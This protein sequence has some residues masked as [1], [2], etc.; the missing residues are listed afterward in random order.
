MKDKVHILAIES[1][2]D[3]TSAAVLEN[4]KVKSNII[5]S[6]NVHQKYGGVVPELASRDHEKNIGWLVDLSLKEAGIDL[7]EIDAIAVTQGPGLLGSLIVGVNFAKSLAM[8][9]E[10]PIIAVNHMEAH[11]LA[12]F[13][14]DPRIHQGLRFPFLAL[15]VSGGHTQLYLW[16]SDV[17]YTIL[18][19]TLDDAAGEAFDKIAKLLGL[20][21]PGGPMIDRLSQKGNAGKFSFP[22][23]KVEDF[24]FSFSGLKTAVLYFLQ[25]KTKDDPD[26]ISRN[27]H[28][29]A[30]SVQKTIVDILLSEVEKAI[31]HTGIR[32]W[33]ICGG[34]SANSL[35]RSEALLLA[36]K[37]KTEVFMLPLEYT[38]DNAAMIGAAAWFKYKRGLFSP[39]SFAAKA[40]L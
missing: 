36:Q 20:P 21:Y 6:Q 2:C 3:D 40:R 4:L 18:G 13:I 8:A 22:H 5:S 34:V 31:A 25:D 11:V 10:R 16:E 19:Q 28:D 35:L 24:H 1:S 15:T 38:T 7:K 30:A 17:Q 33:V 27:L 14:D 29:I 37:T 12:H 39:L 9:I 26:F 23:P 32:Q